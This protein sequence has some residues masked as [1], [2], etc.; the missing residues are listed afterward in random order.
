MKSSKAMVEK[1]MSK[2][3]TQMDNLL[4]NSYLKET[5]L[6]DLNGYLLDTG[7]LCEDVNEILGKESKADASALDTSGIGAALSESLMQVQA[8]QPIPSANLPTFNGEPA[9][10]IPFLESF[11]FIVH[12]N[13]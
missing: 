9:E 7:A 4:D 5:T 2:I 8:R 13:F 12:E 6:S 3:E 1:Q 10:F 11:D